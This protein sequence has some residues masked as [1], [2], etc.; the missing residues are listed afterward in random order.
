MEHNW[1]ASTYR[2]GPAMKCSNCEFVWKPDMNR[3]K[4]SCEDIQISN[5]LKRI[6]NCNQR[7]VSIRKY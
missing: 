7:Y 4:V 2:N 6:K 3:P 1:E 5:E